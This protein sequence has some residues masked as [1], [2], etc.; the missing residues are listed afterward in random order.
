ML[1]D[2]NAETLASTSVQRSISEMEREKQELISERQKEQ[3]EK[4]KNMEKIFAAR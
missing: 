2:Q 4:R 1:R 3:E